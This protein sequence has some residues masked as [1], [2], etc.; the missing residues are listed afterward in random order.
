MAGKRVPL[1][2]GVNDVKTLRPDL[3]HEWDWESN[4]RTPD[5]LQLNSRYQASWICSKCNHKWTSRLNTRTVNNSGCPLCAKDSSNNIYY[6]VDL[7]GILFFVKC[8]N[9]YKDKILNKL[10]VQNQEF[11]N[12]LFLIEEK[13][14]YKYMGDY[15]IYKPYWNS[16]HT[17]PCRVLTSE[18]FIKNI[19]QEEL[20]DY[21]KILEEQRNVVN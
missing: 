12:T 11:I 19:S 13:L 2:K 15:T 4:T 18:F 17:V 20:E 1:I 8:N 7:N 5:T 3:L 16:Y 6:L 9:I 21:F 10:N 14:F